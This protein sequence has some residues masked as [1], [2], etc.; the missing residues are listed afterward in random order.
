M[1]MDNTN[2]KQIAVSSFMEG[3]V[4]P[5]DSWTQIFDVRQDDVASL[6]LA[7]LTGI[8]DPG[9]WDGA[10]DLTTA[11]LDSTGA[12]TMSYQGYGV[13]VRIGKYDAAGDVP[14]I[15]AMAARKLGRS[16]A[17]KRAA[18]AWAHLETA[19]TAG[20]SAIADGKALCASDHTTASGTRSNLAADS[21]LDRSAFL[22]MLKQ[23]FR[24][25]VNY[26]DQ[27]YDLADAPK[28]LVV[29]PDLEETALQIVG[30]P[31]AL[32]SIT[33]AVGG[34]SD[35]S[36]AAAPSQGEIN[37]AGRYNTQVIVSPYLADTNNYYLICD[38]SIE[39][40]LTYWD[41]SPA[42]FRV[43]IDQDNGAVKLS[44]DWA[45]A[46]QSGPQPDGIIGCNKS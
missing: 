31:F 13:Q 43:D 28:F 18:L 19:F 33:R 34:D 44:V 10:S 23:G 15:V 38:P 1:A 11:S 29:P 7:A 16:V 14:G 9:T 37:T 35:T 40:P 3:V 26:Q 25:W 6:R 20:G 2:V 21:A 4:Q 32:T 45:S 27:P 46:T 39:S 22:A 36:T 42:D 24:S 17:S 41:R 12:V 30:S 5:S 8:P